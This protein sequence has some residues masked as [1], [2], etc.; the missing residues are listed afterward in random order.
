MIS[1]LVPSHF[2]SIF[3]EWRKERASLEV[4]TESCAVLPC[5]GLPGGVGLRASGAEEEELRADGPG[6]AF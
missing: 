4:A 3:L 6:D 1:Y 2:F 5:A